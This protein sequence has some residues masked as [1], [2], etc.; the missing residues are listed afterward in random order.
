MGPKG[1][2]I[3]TDAPLGYHAPMQTVAETPAFSRQAEK[4]FNGD[5]RR[6]LIDHLAEPLAGDEISGTGGAERCDSEPPGAVS[7]AVSA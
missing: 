1:S 5:E 7:G 4:L 3:A 6:E 2:G